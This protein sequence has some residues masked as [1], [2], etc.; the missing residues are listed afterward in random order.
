VWASVVSHPCRVR[1]PPLSARM[2]RCCVGPIG[3]T[4]SSSSGRCECIPNPPRSPVESPHPPAVYVGPAQ[5]QDIG[6]GLGSRRAP[7]P[8]PSKLRGPPPA[9]RRAGRHLQRACPLS[10]Q[11]RWPSS[12][13]PAARSSTPEIPPSSLTIA[14]QFRGEVWGNRVA[15]SDRA[16]P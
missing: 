13:T 15:S 10:A 7:P 4:D 2:N 8:L 11:I 14:N 1:I 16:P 3:R 6:M 5:T 12:T 9:A